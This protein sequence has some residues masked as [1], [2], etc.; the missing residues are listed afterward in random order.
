MYINGRSNVP[1]LLFGLLAFI[2]QVDTAM[3]QPLSRIGVDGGRFFDTATE[4]TFNPT[5]F[6]YI[7]LTDD[8]HGTFQPGQYDGNRATAMFNDLSQNGFNTVRVFIDPN[9]GRGIAPEAPS[10]LELNTE[11]LSNYTDFLSRAQDNGIRVITTFEAIPF[12]DRYAAPFWNNPSYPRDPSYGTENQYYQLRSFIDARAQFYADV[13]QVATDAGLA[14]TVLS[15]EIQ[16]EFSFYADRYPFSEVTGSAVGP[17]GIIYSLSDANSRQALADASIIMAS[18]EAV[19][20]IQLVDQDALVGGSIFS[21]HAVDRTGPG[22]NFPTN[23]PDRLLERFPARL[24]ALAE[25][26]LSYLDVHLYPNPAGLGEDFHLAADLASME[27]DA[28]KAS[29]LGADAKPIL[30]GEFG[31]FLR[32]THYPDIDDALAS[33]LDLLNQMQGED[34][35][36]YLY[37]TYDTDEQ[38]DLWNSKSVDGRIF[39]ALASLN[40]VPEPSTSFLLMVGLTAVG[41]FRRNRE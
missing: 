15:Y 31:A 9:N 17:D 38:A 18:N 39:N 37:W 8:K 6:N 22:D 14:S 7:R 40:A 29:L 24:A 23:S 33:I 32:S 34:I 10:S 28:V 35:A 26:D 20:R 12:I 21:F 1:M 3:A 13:A 11:Y 16:N 2:L 36:G 30:M 41:L 27:W 25:S 4:R 5:G 19:R